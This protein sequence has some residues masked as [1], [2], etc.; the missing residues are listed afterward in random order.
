VIST[1]DEKFAKY[2]FNFHNQ[3]MRGRSETP[4]KPGAGTRA[5]NMRL[6]EFQAAVLLAQMTRI[7]EQA[8][9]RTE[10]ANHLTRLLNDIP[11]ISPAKLYPGVTRSAYHLYMFR[12]DR[13]KFAGL[14]RAKFMEALRAEGV[15][16]SGGYGTMNTDTYVT[17][18]ANNK[19]YLRIY[20][21]KVMKEWLERN[22]CPQN[23]LLSEEQGIWF[24]QNLLLGTKT[25]MEQVADGIR[26]IQKFGGELV[27]A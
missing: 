22:V 4:Y 7:Q 19:H 18:L 12:Y 14:S 25:E 26:K 2:C 11:G 15:P 16:C 9:Q 13:T 24:T 10:N 6:T 5:I 8:S 17:E 21:E 1:N 23:N 20:G 3:G 27:K